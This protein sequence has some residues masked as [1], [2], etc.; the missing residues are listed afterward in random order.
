MKKIVLLLT[1]LWLA[2]H[3]AGADWKPVPGRFPMTRWAKR[4]PTNWSS[5]SGTPPLR[6]AIPGASRST[7][8]AASGT[9]RVRASGRRSGH[10]YDLTVKMGADEVHSYFGMRKVSVGPDKDGIYTAPTTAARRP[11]NR[12][13][14]AGVCTYSRLGHRNG[15]SA[16]CGSKKP[17][18]L[19]FKGL[20]AEARRHCISAC[21]EWAERL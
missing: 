5:P 4:V 6:A 3:A 9:R 2:S 11:E 17:Q 13:V 8:P 7:S 14:F 21:P 12:P 18:V 15:I 16:P 10:L 20:T 1:A 19:D